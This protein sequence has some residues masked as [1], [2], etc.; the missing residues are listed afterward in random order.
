MFWWSVVIG[1]AS[2]LVLIAWA[3]G[4]RGSTGGSKAEDRHLNGQERRGGV[5]GWGSG[6]G[7]FQI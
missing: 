5:S 2:V 3:E 6:S 1:L 4:R 7:G